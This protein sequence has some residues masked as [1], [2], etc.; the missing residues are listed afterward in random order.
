MPGCAGV[1][2]AWLVVGH[3]TFW[4]GGLSSAPSVPSCGT[5]PLSWWSTCSV[6]HEARTRPWRIGPW[7]SWV[8]KTVAPA[9]LAHAAQNR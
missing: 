3:T 4:S 9:W 7:A 8:E 6:E 2:P 1:D 5:G